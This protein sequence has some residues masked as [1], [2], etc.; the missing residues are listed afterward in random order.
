MV[1]RSATT[2]YPSSCGGGE[3]FLVQR[4]LSLRLSPSVVRVSTISQPLADV[5]RADTC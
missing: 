1:D 5:K 3:L 2:P 4:G